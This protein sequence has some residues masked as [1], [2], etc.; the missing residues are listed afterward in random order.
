MRKLLLAAALLAVS[1]T[2]A[3]QYDPSS[4]ARAAVKMHGQFAVLGAQCGDYSA[5]QLT[6]QKEQ[7]RQLVGPQ[8]SA[9]DFDATYAQGSAE[10]T[11]KW[12]AMSA[13]QRQQACEQARALMNAGAR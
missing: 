8:L 7:Q 10:A 4:T 6:V 2:S 13:G 9:A 5:A 1:A 12:N 3:A 11:A